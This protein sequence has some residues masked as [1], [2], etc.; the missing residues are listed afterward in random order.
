[1]LGFGAENQ[2]VLQSTQI[3]SVDNVKQLFTQFTILSDV[4]LLQFYD[5]AT[6][7]TNWYSQAEK[8]ATYDASES[9]TSQYRENFW[10]YFK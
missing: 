5:L 7:L 2:R 6:S 3:S 10:Q 9:A 8:C 1:M 4:P